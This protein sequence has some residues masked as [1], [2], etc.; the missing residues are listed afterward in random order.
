MKIQILNL[1]PSFQFTKK[2][3]FIKVIENEGLKKT[4]ITFGKEGAL[5]YDN[6][7]VLY[8]KH[9]KI[10]SN[11]AIGSG[12]SFLAGYLYSH[13]NNYNLKDSLKLAMACGAANTRSYGA[14]LMK[15]EHIKK[16]ETITLRL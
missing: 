1:N 13:V 7:K 11:Y 2:D 3:D 12:D 14:G 5:S 4:I 16:S 6:G 9:T 10:F 15:Y 8:G